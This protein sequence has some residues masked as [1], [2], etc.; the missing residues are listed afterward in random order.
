MT[1]ARRYAFLSYSHDDRALV[2]NLFHLLR[3]VGSVFLDAYELLPGDNW[4]VE[5]EQAIKRCDVL[6]LCWCE[7][8]E[9]SDEVR[10][11][12]ELA[13]SLGKRIVPL[14]IGDLPVRLPEMLRDLNYIDFTKQIMHTMGAYKP[15]D[16]KGRLFTEGNEFLSRADLHELDG[17]LV[18]RITSN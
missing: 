3:T 9:N 14:M 1:T 15:H 10:Q 7:H 8:S 4:R 12:F 16:V 2:T 11:E 5:V 18:R 6:I 13:H 17:Q